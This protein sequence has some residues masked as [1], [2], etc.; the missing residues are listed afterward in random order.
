[1]W[2]GSSDTGETCLAPETPSFP[3]MRL[4]ADISASRGKRIFSL[5]DRISVQAENQRISLSLR[6]LDQKTLKD[7]KKFLLMALGKTG[8]DK[9]SYAPSPKV[10]PGFSFSLGQV[11]GQPIQKEE[12]IMKCME[13]IQGASKAK[14]KL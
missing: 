7:A 13:P 2:M 1:M 11:L 12:I 14:R 8:T 9:A 5:S 10:M 3:L 6:P 4:G